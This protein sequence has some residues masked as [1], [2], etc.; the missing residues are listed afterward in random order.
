MPHSI[1]DYGANTDELCTAEIQQAIDACHEAG[2]GTV[3]VPAGTYSCGTL[4]L[5]SHVNLHLEPGSVLLGSPNRDH[6]LKTFRRHGI[7]YAED[8]EH[9][10][11]TGT[12]VVDGNSPGNYDP[13]RNHDSADWD[14]SFTRQGD[15]YL[16]PDTF[17]VDGPIYRKFNLG[18]TVTFYFCSH[19]VLRDFT[20]KNA[21]TWAVRFGTCENILADN[22]TI[23]NDLCV[24]NSDGI[25]CTASRNVRI[26]N[27]DIRAGDDAIIVSG[28]EPNERLDR[29][30]APVEERPFGN[31]APVSEHVCVSN[32][33]LVSRSSGIRIGYGPYPIRRLSFSNLQ[34]YDSN[35]GI[36]IYAREEAPIE[37]V[38]FDNIT[39]ETRLLD[40]TWW[41]HGEPIHLSTV[42]RFEGRPSAPI[43]RVRFSNILAEA[44][45]GVLLWGREGACLEDIRFQQL[46]L[47]I[48]NGPMV[49]ATGGNF[50][51]RPAADP[52]H[53]LFAHDCPGLYARHID[54]L[55][56][57]DVEVLWDE[58]LPEFYTHGLHAVCVQALE[59]VRC[60]FAANPAATRA[61]AVKIEA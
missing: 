55:Q 42:P 49:T 50:D 14:T 23:L 10:S 36:G 26:V 6:Y 3:L 40:G 32:C 38:F 22:V 11:V 4:V 18:M 16:P 53:S 43:R 19:V 33:H 34:I 21:P 8:A 48:K 25:H 13:T 54:G 39:I 37:D 27:C 52:A 46:R 9:V 17:H 56:L 61:E 57:M 31:K 51:L 5:K 7:L 24:P 1:L 12:G 60:K 47:R 30:I 59:Q 58:D 44:E 28:F 41:G 15:D 29:V 2:G 35:R 45:Q 20:L